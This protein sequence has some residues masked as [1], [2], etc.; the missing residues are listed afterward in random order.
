[1][2][3]LLEALQGFC[4]KANAHEELRKANRDWSR[5][6]G[7]ATREGE[8]AFLQVERGAVRLAAEGIVPDIWLEAPREVLVALFSGDITPTE[9]YLDGRLVLRGGADDLMRLDFISLMIWGE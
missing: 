1:M 7:I 2:S 6:I 9:P 4:G 5:G 8:R 3:E